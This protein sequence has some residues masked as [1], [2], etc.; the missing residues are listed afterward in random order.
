MLKTRVDLKEHDFLNR[1]LINRMKNEKYHNVAEEEKQSIPLIY[2]LT[3]T[4][5]S[6]YINIVSTG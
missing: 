1:R 2:Q 4:A 3:Y 6:M 5:Y